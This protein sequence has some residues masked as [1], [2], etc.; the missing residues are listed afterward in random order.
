MIEIE[1]WV[2]SRVSYNSVAGFF[3]ENDKLIDRSAIISFAQMEIFCRLQ[4]KF[5]FENPFKSEKL[6]LAGIWVGNQ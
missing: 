1:L 5:F 3:F 6:N 2:R 4:T